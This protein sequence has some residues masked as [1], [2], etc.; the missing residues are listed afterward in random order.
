VKYFVSV[1]GR[2]HEV[3]LVDRLGRLEVAVDGKPLD[4]SYRRST[5]SGR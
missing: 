4:L 2:G 5:S 3:E 1:N